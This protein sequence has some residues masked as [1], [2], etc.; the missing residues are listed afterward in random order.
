MKNL[1]LLPLRDILVFPSI[2]VPLFV[3]RSKSIQALEYAQEHGGE[4]FVCLQ[5]RSKTNDPSPGDIHE[6]GT[7]SRIAQIIQ[8]PDST[9]KV[10]VEG[11]R[12]GRVVNYEQSDPL[13]L[14]DVE[15]MPDKPFDAAA[16]EDLVEQAREAFR[17]YSRLNTRV[18]AEIARSVLSIQDVSRFADTMAA[19]LTLKLN[20]KQGIL[21]LDDPAER[22]EKLIELLNAENQIFQVERKIRSRVKKQMERTQSEYMQQQRMEKGQR[23]DA[24]DGDEFKSELE[25][26]EARIKEKDVPDHARERLTREFK[27]LRLMSPMSAEASVIRSYIDVILSLPWNERSDDNLDV[28]R[29]EGILNEDHYGLEKPK[30]RILEYLAVLSLKRNLRGP[31]LCLVGP[32]GVGKTSLARSI[33]RSLD[34]RFV[35]VSLGGVRDEAEI[36]GHRRTYIGALP[37]K[38]IHNLSKTST[39]NPVML[40]D[41]IDKM[42]S[43]FR[44]DPSSALLEVLDP[45]QNAAFN[46]HYLDL[47]YDLS[48]I[49]FVC[50]ANSLSNIPSPLRDRMEII[51]ISGYTDLEK[52]QIARQHLIQRQIL[53]HGLEEYEIRMTDDAVTRLIHGYT[54]EAGVRN[55]EREVGSV[56]R[57]I[58]RQIVRKESEGPFHID[59]DSVVELL[60]PEK[61]H[62]DKVETEDQIGF[63]NG[64]AWTMHGGVLLSAEVS[65]MPGSGKLIITGKLGE[66][67]QESANAAVT[68]VRSR[69]FNLGLSSKFY[70]KIDIHVHFPEGAQPKD[71]PSA[72]VTMVTSL[73]SALTH[74]PVRHD[75]A[76]TGEVTLRGRVLPIGGLKEKIFAAHRT[77]MRTVLIPEDNE[78]DL[79]DVPKEILDDL[80]IISVAYVDEVLGHALAIEDR[81]AFT[82]RLREPILPPEVQGED[83]GLSSLTESLETGPG[84]GV[85]L[86]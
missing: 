74:I 6:I 80:E 53:E 86:S 41:E 82:A 81:E 15:E 45:E 43:D 23:G 64:L 55:L 54:R 11:I 30:D 32:P 70:Q 59:E 66:V 71:G 65:L 47:D 2:E 3:G 20:D 10:T 58:A 26:L 69:A 72:G 35:R 21:E 18:T 31:I 50:T 62:D 39:N 36:R 29:A 48:E 84:V 34:R 75:I 42:T 49:L 25:E 37:G 85:S 83:P 33:A 17:E 22:L 78:K 40:L 77:N 9:V 68:Y 57:K 76:M 27:K 44:G 28:D 5:R 19:Q 8:L 14:V 67:M 56:L 12:R 60:G 63:T 51:E 46:D 7:I 4:I 24:P 13:F 16:N 38:I 79:R 52:L 61:F 73:V 1:P